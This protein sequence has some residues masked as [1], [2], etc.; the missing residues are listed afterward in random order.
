MGRISKAG[1]W[2]ARW[3]LVDAVRTAS[4]SPG[5]SHAFAKRVG[6]RRG[7]NIAAVAVARKLSVLVW[8]LLGKQQD[9]AFAQPSLVATK[10]RRLEL[11][12]GAPKQRRVRRSGYARSALGYFRDIAS[13]MARAGCT[14]RQ[15]SRGQEEACV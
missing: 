15:T 14:L 1:S 9:Y 7:R 6:A 13:G 2:E 5:P 4:K 8:Q 12:A 11:I 10:V 3:A